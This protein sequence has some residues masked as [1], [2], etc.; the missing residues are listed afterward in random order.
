MANGTQRVLRAV[1]PISVTPPS[2]RIWT[3]APSDFAFLWDECR[4]CFYDK[5]V[6]RRRRPAAPFPSVFSRI[7]LAMKAG[8]SGV[9]TDELALG[10][11]AGSII[12]ADRWVKST[13]LSVPG[14]KSRLVV[15]GRVDAL[16]ALD[17]GGI[18]VVDF[19]TAP[20]SDRLIDRYGRQLHAYAAALED[21]ATGRPYRVD[22][23]GILAFIP[24]TFKANS[25]TADLHGELEW[26]EIPLERSSFV[27]F[28]ADVS[29]V[30]DA[31]TAPAA[32]PACPWCT[33]GSNR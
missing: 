32:D 13:P 5:V 3:L 10:A 6:R 2:G 8:F 20:P 23:L 26:T 15:R 16:I 29:T 33:M 4:R 11:P 21:P 17:Q 18:A 31:P 7:D 25:G 9:R 12:E 22:G 30:L 1:E 19:K 28:L 14:S 24:S 27:Q